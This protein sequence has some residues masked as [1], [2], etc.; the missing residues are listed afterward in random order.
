MTA[1]LIGIVQTAVGW[2]GGTTVDGIHYEVYITGEKYN[3]V[4]D[5]AYV[6]FNNQSNTV[7][8]IAN[9]A[10]S[11]TYTY[12][13]RELVGY[14]I[15]GNP[16][17]ETHTRYLMA[18][19]TGIKD[20]YI[21]NH[22]RI[23]G[24]FSCCSELMTV[25]IPNSISFIG[26]QA[27]RECTNLTNIELPNSITSIGVQAFTDCTSLINMIIPNSVTSIGNGAFSGCSGLTSVTIGNSVKSIGSYAFNNCRSLS[28]TLIIPN[29]LR[30]IGDFAFAKCNSF[31][32]LIIDDSFISIGNE[33]FQQC[34]GLTS[35]DFGNH[36][37]SIGEWAFNQCTGLTG[38]LTI[39]S[40]VTSI[41]QGAFM[42]CTS[43]TGINLN[44]LIT[45]INYSTFSF[46]S[47]LESISLPYTLTIIGNQ[48]FSYCTSLTSII[49]PNSVKSIGY[50]SYYH[51]YNVKSINIGNSVDSI[52]QQAFSGPQP[53]ELVWN[54]KRCTTNGGMNTSSIECV[55]IGPDV[56]ILPESFLRSAKITEV[57]IPNSVKSIG[58]YA[59][60]NCS[61]VANITC[62]ATTPPLAQ[63]NSFSK[64]SATLH[65][66][67]GYI[68]AYQTTAPW[69]N[70]TNI[71]GIN[72][73]GDVNGDGGINISDVTALIDLLLSGGEISAGADVNGDGQVNISDVTALIDRLLSGN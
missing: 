3:A 19:V 9:I 72:E 66:P 2:T 28:G 15:N 39:P 32:S 62:L 56:E 16:E 50:K 46:C 27:F 36:V 59:F 67:V 20:G 1:L 26:E 42:E 47:S 48:A 8:P 29:S 38:D 37:T 6:G 71:V 53:T 40:S 68:E 55:T 35:I 21:D 70:F 17:Y 4:A 41:G 10:S 34:S 54:V 7:G 30:S 57:V 43:L 5:S 73:P 22:G 61:N 13:W 65:V 31:T 52:Y 23:I 49:I 58:Q 60:Y 25:T 11:V 14:D 45:E 44:A 51:C 18:P 63:S 12:S 64:Y 33:A 69:S 24:A